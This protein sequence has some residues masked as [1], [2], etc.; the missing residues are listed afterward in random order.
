[1]RVRSVCVVGLG[2]IGLPTAALLARSGYEVT[3]MDINATAVDTVNQGRIHIVE[4][5]LE[6]CVREVVLAGRLVASQQICKADV[7][8]ICV[9]TPFNLE[10]GQ[11]T[12]IPRLL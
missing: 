1:M 2:Y 8:I 5:D 7:F 12:R 10:G 6:D 11:P 3:G 4:P 9:P